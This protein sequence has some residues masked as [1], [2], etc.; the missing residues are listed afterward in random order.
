MLKI[1]TAKRDFTG[2]CGNRVKAGEPFL[3]VELRPLFISRKAA[4]QV[5]QELVQDRKDS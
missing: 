5:V 2:S 3:L 1:R 4:A